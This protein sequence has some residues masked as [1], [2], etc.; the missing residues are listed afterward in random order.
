MNATFQDAEQIRKEPVFFDLMNLITKY[1]FIK[2]KQAFLPV[3]T[4]SSALNY[5]IF[6]NTTIAISGNYTSSRL[7][8]YAS[9]DSFPDIIMKT[10]KISSHWTLNM[11]LNHKISQMINMTFKINNIFDAQYAEQFG[12]SI[13]DKDYPR[14]GRCIFL[15]FE[16]RN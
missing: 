8:Y 12:N 5:Q 16:I 10:K 13:I 14:P 4:L 6:N 15:G 11:Y 7:N 2:R 9:Y 3:F 1:S